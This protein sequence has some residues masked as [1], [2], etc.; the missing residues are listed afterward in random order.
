MKQAAPAAAAVASCALAFLILAG[1]AQAQG[2]GL[3]LQRSLGDPSATRGE[4]V[5]TFV[6]AD[7]IEGLGSAEVEAVGDAE[8]RRGD[9]RLTADRIKYFADTDEVE[10]TGSVR[11][12]IAGDEVSGP[13]L[14]L[15]IEDTSG[16]FDQPTFRLG[17][18]SVAVRGEHQR[19]PVLTADPGAPTRPQ[20]YVETRGTAKALRFDG[21]EQYRMTDAS[22]TTCRPGQDDWFIEAGEIDIDMGREVGTVRDARL[23]FLGLSTPRLPWWDF[24]LNNQRKSGFLPP[25]AGTQNTTGFEVTLPFYWNIA[26]NYDATIAP[27]YMA[28]R[29]VQF[30]NQFRFLQ[31]WAAGELRY[32][33]LP[34][35]RVA[36]DEYRYGFAANS[37]LN[38]GNGWTGLVNYNRVSDDNYFRDLSGRLSVATQLFLPQQG[39]VTYLSPSGEWTAYANMQRFQTLQDPQNP[40]TQPYFREPQLVFNGLRQTLGG[41]DA[42]L[43]AEYVNFTNS[44]LVPTGART[45]A[46]PAVSLPLVRSYGYVLPKVG[47]SATWYSLA[48]PGT[49]TE[50]SLSRTLPIASVDAGLFFERDA[51]WLGTDFVQTFEPRVY[52]LYVPFKNQSNI[53]VFDTTTSDLNVSQLFQENIFAGGDRIANANQVSIAATSRLVRPSDGQE[54]VRAVIGQR[55]YFADQLV[56]IPGEPV[57]TSSQTPLILGLG[58]RIAQDWSA[59]LG[60]QYRFSG[61]QNVEKFTAAVRY[62]P[63]PA[64]VA[65]ISYRYISQ[66]Y[67]AGAGTINTVDAAAQWP[68]GGGLYGVGRV[69]YDLDGSKVVEALAGLE[70][71]AGCWIVRGVVQQ[72]QTATAQQTEAFFIQLELNG[73]ARIGS[74]PIELL[75]RNIPGYTLLNQARPGAGVGDIAPIGGQPPLGAASPAQI[76]GGPTSVYRYYD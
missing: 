3:R 64:S 54:L 12:R 73:V 52:Y 75:R 14:R 60:L 18:R 65:S 44:A 34:K 7:R 67:T 55:Y 17:E 42:G 27:R 76:P 46:Y 31:P 29:G 37:S 61:G 33:F 9:T 70:Y 71:N 63:A 35:D 23:N 41:F 20:T 38:F 50:T 49:F 57:R 13:R 32:D 4:D 59:D 53:P 28:R 8:L 30:L 39:L 69:S 36:D 47:V 24:S 68:L 16:I 66:D 40:V 62:S 10:A 26:P 74:N 43:A 48:E 56:T 22:F 19:G 21:D 6:T 2:Q 45:T 5:P 11:L 51:R 58:G 25:T 72:F 15:R 1:P